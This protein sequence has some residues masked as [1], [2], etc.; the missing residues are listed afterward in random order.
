MNRE[1]LKKISRCRI[2]LKKGHWAEDCTAGSKDSKKVAL[3]AFSYTGNS[4]SASHAA[5]SFLS[6]RCFG[7]FSEAFEASWNFLTFSSNEAII[8][9]GATQDLIGV[10]CL[11]RLEESLA[12]VGLRA[13]R[14]EA[15]LMTPSGIGGSAKAIGTVL[16]PVSPGGHPG[17][18]EM[19]ILEGCIPPLLSVGFLDFLQS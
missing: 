17:V 4:S 3:T 9:I 15:P 10:Q 16:I 8:D 12:E 7:Q 6:G 11:K 5:F 13:V 18:L 14:V 19:T 1:Q 2:C